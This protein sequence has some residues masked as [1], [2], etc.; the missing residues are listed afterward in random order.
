MDQLYLARNDTP[1]GH[2]NDS[3]AGPAVPWVRERRRGQGVIHS[4]AL[5]DL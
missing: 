3:R 2:R 5:L 4:E 1:T